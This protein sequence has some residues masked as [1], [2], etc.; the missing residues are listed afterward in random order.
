MYE[1][2]TLR[3]PSSAKPRWIHGT[4]T[5]SVIEV[6][7]DGAVVEEL[8]VDGNTWDAL[9]IAL[10]PAAPPSAG[11]QQGAIDE[12]AD[13]RHRRR[14]RALPENAAADILLRRPPRTVRRRP[15]AA[16]SAT[17]STPSCGP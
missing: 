15:A 17:M 4:R 13:E 8:A 14:A 5:V 1:L 3:S 2:P 16:S 7:D 6:L 11:R 10:T 12:W 9:P